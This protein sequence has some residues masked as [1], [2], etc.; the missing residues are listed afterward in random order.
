MACFV[1][2]GCK[3]HALVVYHQGQDAPSEGADI[4]IHYTHLFRRNEIQS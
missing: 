1:A 4:I 3:Q 2:Q